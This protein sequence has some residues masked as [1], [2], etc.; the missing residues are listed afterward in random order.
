M[1]PNGLMDM[2]QDFRSEISDSGPV[3]VVRQILFCVPK[4]KEQTIEDGFIAI[5]CF[6]FIK[7]FSS[8]ILYSSNSC[9]FSSFFLHVGFVN[10]M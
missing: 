10:V 8:K 9:S 5:K 4:F 1:R 6:D 7:S 3:V 2:A